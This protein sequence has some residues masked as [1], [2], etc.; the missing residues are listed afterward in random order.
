MKVKTSEQEESRKQFEAWFSPRKIAMQKR[1]ISTIRI[2]RLHK[3]MLEA[4][5]ASRAA[6]EI[7]LPDKVMVEDEFDNGHNCAIDYCADAIRAAG[8]TVKGE[9]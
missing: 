7:D 1:G 3:K 2:V 5:Q 8:L 9:W 4:W 6:I